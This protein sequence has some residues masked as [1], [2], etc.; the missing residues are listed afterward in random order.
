MSKMNAQSTQVLALASSQ[1]AHFADDL[2][3]DPI[4]LLELRRDS[5][6]KSKQTM[7]NYAQARSH[8]QHKGAIVL[9]NR[10]KTEMNNSDVGV[11][12][13]SVQLL[14]RRLQ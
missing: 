13:A 10:F 6:N 8:S 12:E 11:G 14:A 2:V 9:L 7:S 3:R 4:A 5:A 1:A